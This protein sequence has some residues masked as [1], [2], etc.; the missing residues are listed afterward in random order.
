M[1]S[2][3]SPLELYHFSERVKELLRFGREA[4]NHTHRARAEKLTNQVLTASLARAEQFAQRR[5]L[6]DH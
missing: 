6:G 1:P 3:N 5:Q 2:L 4:G